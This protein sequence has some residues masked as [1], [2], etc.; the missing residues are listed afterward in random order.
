[1][2][3]RYALKQEINDPSVL[4]GIVYFKMSHYILGSVSVLESKKLVLAERMTL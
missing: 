2:L 3:K 4:A 1:M